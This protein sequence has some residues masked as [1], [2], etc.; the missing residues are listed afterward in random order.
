MKAVKRL[1]E[2]LQRRVMLMVTK[3]V[4]SLIDDAGGLQRLQVTLLA[5]ETRGNVPRF[6]EYGFSAH[7]L[8]GATAIVVSISGLRDQPIIIALDDPRHRPRD[9]KQGEVILY[10]DL[11]QSIHLTRDGIVVKGAGKPITLTDTP[12]V[13]A[14]TPL[15]ECTGEIKDRCDSDG[16]S[17]SGM[18]SVYDGHN[19][20]GDSGGLTTDP[21]QKMN[22]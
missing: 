3:A 11:G 10:D 2:P 19:H 21:N 9:L 22:P 17:M 14:E 18:R 5:N 4:A 7:P 13:R 1:M 6:Q 20:G 8:P 16:V 12:K 15:F